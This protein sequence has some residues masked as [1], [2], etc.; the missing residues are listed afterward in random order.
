MMIKVMLKKAL[1]PLFVG[2]ALIAVYTPIRT[3]QYIAVGLMVLESLSFI[4]VDGRR[5][6]KAIKH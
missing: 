5:L 1:L 4:V 6:L 3:V 2:L